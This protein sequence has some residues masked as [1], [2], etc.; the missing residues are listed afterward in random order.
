MQ[1]PW[2][3]RDEEMSGELPR[4]IRMACKDVISCAEG[5]FCTTTRANSKGWG[6]IYLRLSTMAVINEGGALTDAEVMIPWRSPSPLILV[7]D[8]RQLPPK[9]FSEGKEG[10]TGRSINPFA[11]CQTITLL[12]RL[13][14]LGWSIL[15]A[16]EQLRMAVGAFNLANQLIYGN[17]VVDGNR[18]NLISHP[19]AVNF[20]KWSRRF[21]L[22]SQPSRVWSFFVDVKGSSHFLDGTS[23]VLK[24]LEYSGDCVRSII[25]ELLDDNH[26]D[27]HKSVGE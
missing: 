21:V 10:K 26:K 6:R 13:E 20:E 25:I 4:E 1:T 8:T 18:S 19:L 16:N 2:E 11:A 23:K 5:L 27:Y 17:K 24:S 7:G 12:E 9:G 3:S 15:H 14:W 22:P